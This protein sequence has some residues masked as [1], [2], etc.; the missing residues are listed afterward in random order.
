MYKKIISF[1]LIFVCTFLLVNPTR[2]AYQCFQKAEPVFRI[3]DAIMQPASRSLSIQGK[4]FSGE[5]IAAVLDTGL[6]GLD[7]AVVPGRNIIAGNRNTADKHGHGTAMAIEVLQN[8]VGSVKIMPVKVLDDHGEGNIKDIAKGIRWAADHNADIINMSF[9]TYISG[10]VVELTEAV[11]YAKKKGVLL[12]ASAGNY[13]TSVQNFFPASID[14]VISCSAVDAQGNFVERSNVDGSVAIMVKEQQGTSHASAK[15]AALAAEMLLKQD[16]SLQVQQMFLEKY[17]NNIGKK[18]IKLFQGGIEEE[19]VAIVAEIPA[20]RTV[21]IQIMNNGKPVRNAYVDISDSVSEGTS[22]ALTSKRMNLYS[23]TDRIV[24]FDG[25]TDSEGYLLLFGYE[26]DSKTYSRFKLWSD[27]LYRVEIEAEDYHYVTYIDG[28]QITNSRLQ[29]DIDLTGYVVTG[30]AIDEKGVPCPYANVIIVQTWN[31]ISAD[32]EGFFSLQVPQDYAAVGEYLTL[33]FSY[34]TEESFIYETCHL[35]KDLHGTVDLG[36]VVLKEPVLA[37]LDAEIFSNVTMNIHSMEV[38]VMVFTQEGIPVGIITTDAQFNT[39]GTD[40][41]FTYYVEDDCFEVY[42]KNHPDILIRPGTY[43]FLIVPGEDIPM[44]GD[45]ATMKKLYPR[46]KAIQN[47]N[48]VKGEQ[49]HLGNIYLD[50]MPVV[51]EPYLDS[52]IH[53]SSDN[54]EKEGDIISFE[55]RFA[56]KDRKGYGCKLNIQLPDSLAVLEDSILAQ[57]E[58]K[59]TLLVPQIN[60]SL[61]TFDFG[62]EC[63]SQDIY[64]R[65]IFKARVMEMDRPY[66]ITDVWMLETEDGQLIHEENIARSIIESTGAYLLIPKGTN[67][68][69]LDIAGFIRNGTKMDIYVDGKK[70][71]EAGS[72]PQGFFRTQLDLPVDAQD[73][74]QVFEIYGVAQDGKETQ[75]Y[76][77]V[78][79]P[80]MV[81]MEAIAFNGVWYRFPEDSQVLPVITLASDSVDIEV[82]FSDNYRIRD[83]AA[84]TENGALGHLKYDGY[85]NSFKGKMYLES[86]QIGDVRITY[87]ELPECSRSGDI[88]DQI[89]AGAGLPLSEEDLPQAFRPENLQVEEISLDEAPDVFHRYD[90]EETH[91]Y[92]LTADIGADEPYIQYYKL[93]TGVVMDI[94]DC[95]PVRLPDGLGIAWDFEA[96]YN[97]EQGVLYERVVLPAEMLDNGVFNPQGQ[98]TDVVVQESWNQVPS[99]ILNSSD[100]FSN[101]AG[102]GMAVVGSIKSSFDYLKVDNQLESLKEAAPDQAGRNEV[103]SLQNANRMNYLAKIGGTALG[104]ILPAAFGAPFWVGIAIGVGIG[105]LISYVTSLIDSWIKKRIDELK[106]F[107]LIDPSGYVYEGLEENTLQ[108]VTTTIYYKEQE[109]GDFV[110]WNAADF[111]QKNPQVTDS[112]GYYGWDVLPGIWQVKYEKEGYDPQYS[113][114]LTVPPVHTDVN[115]GMVSTLPPQVKTITVD[116]NHEYITVCMDKPIKASTLNAA[117]V[118][119]GGIKLTIDKGE[120]DMINS[121][122]IIPKKLLV[123]GAVYELTIKSE[124]VGYNGLKLVPYTGEITIK[125]RDITPP[126]EVENIQSAS[127]FK[128]ILLHWEPSSS[129]DVHKILVAYKSV[130]ASEFTTVEAGAEDQSIRLNQLQ[131]DTLYTIRITVVDHAGFKSRGMAMEVCTPDVATGSETYKEKA[132]YRLSEDLEANRAILEYEPATKMNRLLVIIPISVFILLALLFIILRQRRRRR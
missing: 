34:Q 21:S 86:D 52:A 42:Q 1:L 64:G 110:E 59:K 9:G 96:D 32:E 95:Q 79:N 62:E 90:S 20:Q 58:G 16:S 15:G 119:L 38:N 132:P 70:L 55:V 130:A 40:T 85:G 93:D 49:T 5:I 22:S 87:T 39:Y 99:I 116:N 121:F 29:I 71:K 37:R 51:A 77:I 67:E 98:G 54:V 126:E 120:A 17:K 19:P 63:A 94:R 113:E 80:G 57:V 97:T 31:V 84:S 12:F 128:Q 118:Q 56:R 74:E 114:E 8:S 47:I 105:V 82:S 13:G 122:R 104:L 69:R 61:I 33:G 125:E 24:Q 3:Q 26:D 89:K 115:I 53:T 103:E 7:K 109:K 30:R 43:N 44:N 66:Y 108:G 78:Y 81:V 14:G 50:E 102:S 6:N 35:N 60:K 124:S 88:W 91:I 101:V 41:T 72:L 65:V 18:T 129:T 45:F 83:V 111:L 117:Q 127:D 68:S 48:L 76:N 2:I 11:D 100:F 131:P 23:D 92:K 112:D 10:S 27:V 123:T 106:T 28:S 36:N 4:I 25:R 46:A 75:K 107:W 73:Q